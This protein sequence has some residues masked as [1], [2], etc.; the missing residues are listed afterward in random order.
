[1]KYGLR[2]KFNR[3]FVK[4]SGTEIEIGVTSKPQKGKAN[5][6]I[7]KKLA[8]HFGVPSSGVRIVSGLKSK[9]KIVE[10]V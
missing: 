3:N 8:K 1:L 5:A 4:V 9:N 6:E 10:I 7:I 2:V